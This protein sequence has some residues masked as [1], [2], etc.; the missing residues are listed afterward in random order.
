[1]T[2]L[3]LRIAWRELRGGI[4]GLRVVI[5]CLALGV[6]AIAAVGTLRDAIL[7]GIG[8]Q[9]STLL[10]GDAELALAYRLASA[11]ERAFMESVATQVSEIVDFRSM[12]VTGPYR[13]AG[14][15]SDQDA[16]RGAGEGGGDGAGRPG[17]RGEGRAPDR[18]EDQALTQVRAVDDA[19]PLYGRAELDPPMPLAQ[20]LAGTGGLP[21]AVM[22]PV[23]IARLGLAPGDSF[24]LGMQEFR[25]MAALLHE[26]DGAGAGFLLGPRTLVRHADLA[27]SGLLVPGALFEARYRLALPGGTDLPALRRRVEREFPAAGLRWRDRRNPV[28]GLRRFVGGIGQFLVLAGLAT[29]AVGGIG[30]AAA[31]RAWLAE[32]VATIATFKALGAGSGLI[33][34]SH[35]AQIAGAGG[36]GIL[37]GLALGSA[38][39]LAAAPLVAGSLPFGFAP[40]PSG[41]ALAE[42]AFLGAMTALAFTLI[43]LARAE[44]IPPAA[45]YRGA[46]PRARM[47]MRRIVALL[48]LVAGLAG[49]VTLGSENPRLALGATAAMAG[50]L[51]LLGLAGEAMRRLCRRLAHGAPARGR[52][53]LRAALAALGA[54]GGGTVATTMALGLGLAVLAA[55]GQID[56]NLRAA[57]AR[58]LPDR[59]PAFFFVDIQPDQ[60]GPFRATLAA[61]PGTRDFVSAPML[62]GTI[63]AVNG[64]PASEVKGDHW[65]LRGDRGVSYAGAMPAGTVIT[66]GAWWPEGYSGPPQASLS[67]AEAEDLGLAPGATITVSILGREITATVTSLREVDFTSGGMGFV[68]ILN[69]AA[70]AGAPHGNLATIHAPPGA[71]AAILKEVARDFPNVTAISIRETAARVV[72]A[73]DLIAAAA[74]WAAAATLATGVAVLIGTAAAGEEARRREAAI[75]KVLGASRRRIMASLALRSGLVGLLAGA[76]AVGAGSLGAWVALDPVMGLSYRFAPGP[77]LAITGAGALMTLATGLVLARRSLGARPAAF[78]RAQD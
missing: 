34:R 69:E 40:A 43:P 42:A 10:G 29:L 13:G 60:L 8:T 78:L 20:A 25:L 56:A 54:R 47:R 57:I 24:R 2:M 38:L 16:G 68:V 17:T 73:L 31:T 71:E 33:F 55:I 74:A 36:L 32:R 50:L 14:Q 65:V 76:V 46:A 67:R 44:A 66:G 51:G 75:L 18:H 59:A 39:F 52:P 5:L 4:G 61:L 45:L 53:A 62:R 22:D 28:P 27:R 26:P 77:A 7:S 64:R 41:R 19:W 48:A 37:L 63:T 30:I 1:M 35:L 23:L 21:G 3:A 9:G 58:D 15:G 72:E 11:D 6:G 70:L 49:A 12:A